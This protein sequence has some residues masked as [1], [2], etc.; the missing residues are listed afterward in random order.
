MYKHNTNYSTQEQIAKSLDYFWEDRFVTHI[1]KPITKVVNEKNFLLH[2]YLTQYILLQ[3]T[4]RILKNG[5]LLCKVGLSYH[6][7]TWIR[8]K[9][10][11]LQDD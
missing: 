6:K 10:R 4:K 11:S 7:I 3:Y 1:D 9:V 2:L 5:N 8:L